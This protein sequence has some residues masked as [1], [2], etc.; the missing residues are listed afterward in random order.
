MGLLTLPRQCRE[1]IYMLLPAASFFFFF[2]FRRAVISI[3]CEAFHFNS[4]ECV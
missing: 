2:F 1:F 3:R 4:E